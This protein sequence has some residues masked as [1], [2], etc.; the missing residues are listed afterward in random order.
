MISLKSELSI[1]DPL[2]IISNTITKH[3]EPVFLNVYDLLSDYQ[4]VHC[5]FN[6]CVCRVFGAYHTVSEI[7]ITSLIHDFI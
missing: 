3:S 1:Q 2:I 4:P 6:Y 5:F 7:R